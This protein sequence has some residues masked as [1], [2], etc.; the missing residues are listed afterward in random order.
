[1][2][3]LVDTSVWSAALRR[4]ARGHLGAKQRT[5]VEELSSL[6]E[7]ARA[8]MAGC[9]RQ[10]VLSGVASDTQFEKL[11]KKL[12]A[13]DDLTADAATYEL[14]ASYFNRCRAQGIQGSHIDFL[15]CAL[16]HQHAAPILTLDSDFARYAEV[17]ELELHAPR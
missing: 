1:M 13:F 16:S 5:A 3:V 4:R 7:D 14:A 11:R 6:I 15:I 12:R 17:C 9:I 8:S 10:E 2:K